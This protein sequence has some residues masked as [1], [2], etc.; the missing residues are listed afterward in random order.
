MHDV[1]FV[2]HA[3]AP[4]Y[5]V[6]RAAECDAL[7]RSTYDACLRLAERSGVRS[8]AF[9]A[10][11]TGAGG[12][13]A[14]KAAPIALAATIDYLTGAARPVELILFVLPTDST[15]TAFAKALASRPL[16]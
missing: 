4:E 6:V 9:P 8:V 5:S 11:G 2:I 16:S 1:R 15:Y 12:F 10:L 7:L 3:V 13:L 14:R